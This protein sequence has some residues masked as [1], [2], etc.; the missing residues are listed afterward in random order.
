MS[1]KEL[2]SCQGNFVERFVFEMNSG[3]VES[4][5]AEIAVMSVN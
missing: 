5:K 3:I 2:L 1:F 4:L